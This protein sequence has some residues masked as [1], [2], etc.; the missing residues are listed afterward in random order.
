MWFAVQQTTCDKS[1]PP[2]RF[3][4][5]PL[6]LD[7]SASSL[8]ADDRAASEKGAGAMGP[9]CVSSLCVRV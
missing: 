8:P 4:S 2:L 3:F 6:T 1:I 5:G 7:A 9:A